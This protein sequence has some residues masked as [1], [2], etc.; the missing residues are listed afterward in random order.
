M[1]P[2]GA[3]AESRG[4]ASEPVNDQLNGMRERM[5][6]GSWTLQR[7]N[8]VPYQPSGLVEVAA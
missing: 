5:Q 1:G 3:E 6:V 4:D 8:C 2:K 7:C